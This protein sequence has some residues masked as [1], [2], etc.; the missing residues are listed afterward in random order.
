M[1]TKNHAIYQNNKKTSLENKE[2]E[3]AEPVQMNICQT[4]TY[5]KDLSWLYFDDEPRVQ[6]RQQL[7]DQQTYISSFVAYLTVPSRS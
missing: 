1:V 7:M 3:L 2:V 6:Q 5:G 4:N